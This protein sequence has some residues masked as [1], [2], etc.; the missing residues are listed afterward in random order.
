MRA[1]TFKKKYQTNKKNTK[2]H[3]YRITN[4]IR[5]SKE[6]TEHTAEN[7]NIDSEKRFKVSLVNPDK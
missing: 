3:E 4:C 6:Q 7:K 5:K 2:E 1:Q